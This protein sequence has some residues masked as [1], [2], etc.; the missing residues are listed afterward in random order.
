MKLL[1][2]PAALSLA[3]CVETIDT[4]P[5]ICNSPEY[6]A[7]V[8]AENRTPD[9]IIDKNG[10]ALPLP[11]QAAIHVPCVNGPIPVPPQPPTTPPTDPEP[12]IDPPVDPEPPIEPPL[13][14]VAPPEPECIGNPGN[15][16]CVGRAGEQDKGD[17][18]G[19]IHGASN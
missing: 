9:V 5:M 6:L 10:Q 14:P 19:D 12:P 17:D 2:I 11:D 4:T 16:K 7:T 1:L 3:A 13:P 8:D 15:D 18:E